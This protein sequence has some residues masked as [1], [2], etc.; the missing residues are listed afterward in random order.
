MQY[1]LPSRSPL[2]LVKIFF[3]YVTCATLV[4]GWHV[5]RNLRC[6]VV[7]DW[8]IN[9][10]GGFVRRGL[11]GQLAY[12][13]GKS[14]RVSPA[15]IVSV[16]YV[17]L[18][19]WFLFS[20]FR[21]A[22]RSSLNTWVLALLLSPAAFSMQLLNPQAGFHKEILFLAS[23]A[24]FLVWLQQH[25]HPSLTTAVLLSLF[26]LVAILSHESLLFYLPYF[27]AAFL[28]SGKTFPAGVRTLA[29]PAVIAIST[30]YIC[31]RHLGSEQIATHICNSL[32][33]SFP[34]G[35]SLDVCDGGAILY[36]TR[37]ASFARMETLAMMRSHHYWKL[38]TLPIPVLLAL[39]PAIGESVVLSR[40]NRSRAVWIIWT[41]AVVS[42][43]STIVLFVF[44]VDWGRWIYIHIV[45]ITL[46]LLF[47]DGQRAETSTAISKFTFSGSLT[48][49][50]TAGVLL[51]LYATVWCL[52]NDY[53][54][55][56][57]FG[58]AGRAY[59]AGQSI[60]ER[61]SV[62]SAR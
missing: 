44:A 55:T 49:M 32:G 59:A 37:S 35:R 3:A 51:F 52:P 19:V 12:I 48:G 31:S 56:A 39:I 18:S 7:S 62:S 47:S 17:A 29:F 6:W 54:T 40:T 20:A 14:L 53:K 58:Y 8:L 50:R 1:F 38:I 4:A 22:S 41:A 57:L 43:L 46:C 23:L 21:L 30:A 10:E 42:F 45:S 61:G 26:S 16:F 36:L 9:Y 15:V 24:A 60:L 11:P 2:T 5:S 13:V 34:S 27:F 28:L 25:E 33:Y